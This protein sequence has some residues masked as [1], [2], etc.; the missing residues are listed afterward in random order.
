MARQ[1]LD[2]FPDSEAKS[3]LLSFCT[4]ATERDR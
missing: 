3:A 2:A 1:A 4:F